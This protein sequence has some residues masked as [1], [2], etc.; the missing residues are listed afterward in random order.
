MDGSSSTI[1]GIWASNTSDSVL[2]DNLYSHNDYGIMLSDSFNN[3]LAR[4]EID[5]SGIGILLAAGSLGNSLEENT[6][7]SNTHYGIV[8]FHSPNNVL[9]NNS[10]NFNGGGIYL[11]ASADNLLQGNTVSSNSEEGITI[12]WSTGNTIIENTCSENDAGI[13]LS[14]SSKSNS[15]Y[16]NVFVDNNQNTSI[17]VNAGSNIWDDGYPSGGNYW[18][19]YS[20]SD[21]FSGQDQDQPGSDGIGDVPYLIPSEDNIPG[22]GG[23]DNYPLMQYGDDPN[24]SPVASF[25]YSPK[26]SMVGQEITFDA[27]E[28]SDIDGEITSYEWNFGDDV[29]ASGSIVKHTYADTGTY[30]VTLVVIDSEESDDTTT[31]TIIIIGLME[32]DVDQNGYVTLKDSTII[33]K[34][35]TGTWELD[36]SQLVSADTYDNDEVTLRDSTLIKKWLVNPDTTLWESPADDNMVQPVPKP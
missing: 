17:T 3:T 24:I 21:M 28:S 25:T 30:V 23:T 6:L 12:E 5:T 31:A 14:I 29:T 4:N 32:G 1:P 11:N 35:L 16:G 22:N 10:A 33:K 18:S 26:H 27:S 9:L 34:W 19:D 8:L 15:I 7:E 36:E 20:G 2:S 13:T